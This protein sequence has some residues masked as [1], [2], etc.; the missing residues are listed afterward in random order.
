[1]HEVLQTEATNFFLCH[2]IGINNSPFL[3][4]LVYPNKRKKLVPGKQI[5]PGVIQMAIHCKDFRIEAF[6]F[7]FTMAGEEQKVRGTP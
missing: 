4:F 3:A 2:L 7:K 5:K 1:M 6:N